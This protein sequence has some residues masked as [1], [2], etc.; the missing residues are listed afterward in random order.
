MMTPRVGDLVVGT[1]NVQ[2]E[3]KYVLPHFNPH[4][5]FLMNYN[6]FVYSESSTTDRIASEGGLGVINNTL[7]FAREVGH[8]KNYNWI[9]V[10][11][12]KDVEVL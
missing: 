1:D 7:Y 5:P 10:W 4:C 2:F 8:W 3:L 12:H 11:V 6:L 9:R